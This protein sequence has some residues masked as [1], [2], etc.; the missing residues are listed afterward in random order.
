MHKLRIIFLA[1]AV[2]F[3]ARS[4]ENPGYLYKA[5][6]A[7]AVITPDRPMPMAGYGARKKP[8]EGKDQD[9]YGK[10]LAIEDQKGNRV[11][12]ITLDL[13]GVISELRTAVENGL[14]ED[15]KLPAHALVMNASHTHCGP[16]YGRPEL[17]DY[18]DSIVKKL[19]A[20][21]TKAIKGMQPAK[22]SYAHAKCAFAMNRRT[23]TDKGFRNHPNPN[24]PV[25]HTVPVLR[26]DDTEGKLFAVM[27]GYSCHNTSVG[28]L[29]WLGDY[30]GFAQQYFEEDH[31]GV[32]AMFM[33]NCGGDQNPYP[34][35]T[36][37]WAA[38][39]GRSLATAVEAALEVTQRYFYHQN[40]LKGGIQT[41]L[42]HVNLEFTTEKRD[43]FP[44]PVQVIQFGNDLT[45]V[46]LGNEVTVDY[47]LRLKRELGGEGK[48]VIW[49]AGY[50]NVYS[51]Y[52]PSKRVL[53]EG[54][55]EARSRP[56]KPD[57]E[58]RI[59]K[60]AHELFHNFN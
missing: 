59:I 18:F 30:A 37:E 6:V 43:P 25:D 7:T 28:Y 14:A 53:L 10:V 27:F 38:K 22:L 2:S 3:T 12:F 56:W 5:G 41:A 15:H 23:P 4:A 51:G 60:T 29:R 58:E 24:G 39:H 11:V 8:A 40:R 16:A 21:T 19:R 50:S 54:G 42:K 49:V 34:R 33:M 32:T 57:L 17:K 20:A 52:I 48:P 45:F 36:A 9:L 44:Y 31:P 1:I 26:V 55:Y 47:S 46:T 35:G 13:I